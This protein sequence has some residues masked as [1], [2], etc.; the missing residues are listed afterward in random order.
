[1]RTMSEPDKDTLKADLRAQLRQPGS[2][3]AYRWF[4]KVMV[5]VYIDG[6][7]ATLFKWSPIYIDEHGRYRR[8]RGKRHPEAQI[9][10]RELQQVRQA[11]GLPADAPAKLRQ[12]VFHQTVILRGVCLGE[13]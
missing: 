2:D 9:T 8:H 1:M 12:G 6:N 7:T 3:Q 5:T 4:G 11:L 10:H 13:E